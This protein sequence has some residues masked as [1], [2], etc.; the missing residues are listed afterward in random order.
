MSHASAP[1]TPK[2]KPLAEQSATFSAPVSKTSPLA[3]KWRLRSQSNASPPLSS[4]PPQLDLFASGSYVMSGLWN[5]QEALNNSPSPSPPPGGFLAM[6]T[7]PRN[8]SG[9]IRI[10]TATSPESSQGKSPWQTNPHSNN[11]KTSQFIDKLQAENDRLRR[12][13]TAEKLARE[14]DL[15]RLGA[16]K[17]KAEDSRTEHQHLQV[18][19]DTNARALERKDRKLEELK[20]TLEAEQRRR[21]AAEE[22]EAEMSRIL[23]ETRSETQRELAKAVTLQ[24]QAETHAEAAQ[25]GFKRIQDSYEHKVRS[26]AK[27]LAALKKQRADDAAKI[28]KQAIV[29]DQLAQECE[30][31]LRSEHS[32]TDLL[33]AYRKEHEQGLEALVAEA[34][35]LRIAV[36]TKE[37]AADG[38]VE[39]MRQI[40]DKMKWVMTQKKYQEQKH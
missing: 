7:S 14:E 29:G 18:L 20:A 12:D 27:D 40:A 19:A 6:H 28:K 15:R 23:G 24:Q 3:F 10:D 11:T 1:T 33:A 31:A 26:M 36:P 30:K 2:S 5:A 37:A 17:A 32:M 34:R 4:K 22:R 38:L 25:S 9:P 13:L 39:E 16:A 8:A 21:I 35:Q